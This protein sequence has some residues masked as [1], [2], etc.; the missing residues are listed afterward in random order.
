MFTQIHL[1]IVLIQRISTIFTDKMSTFHVL[2][3]P[4]SRM[5]SEFSSVY[6]CV[7]HTS[8]K[9]EKTRFK[10]ALRIYFNAHSFYSVYEFLSAF[11]KLR[12][13]T[14]SFVMSVC[15]P[16]LPHGTLGSH[17]TYLHEN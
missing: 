12:K 13:T 2:R 11:A 6:H 17:S 14:V 5:A 4:H 15:R 9:H 10:V 7:S 3:E 8:L 1:Y 16:V